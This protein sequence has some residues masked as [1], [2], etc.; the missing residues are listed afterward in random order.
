[1]CLKG[2]TQFAHSSSLYG[3]QEKGI[4]HIY[5][6]V[7]SLDRILIEEGGQYRDQLEAVFCLTSTYTCRE[8]QNQFKMVSFLNDKEIIA[9]KFIM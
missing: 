4:A 8:Y 1:M 5:S 2:S 7:L 3:E 6:N 9:F